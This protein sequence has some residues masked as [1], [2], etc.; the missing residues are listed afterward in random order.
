MEIRL[1]K[2]F[3]KLV[4]GNIKIVQNAIKGLKK[5]WHLFRQ[6]G[7]FTIMKE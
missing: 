3:E 4:K 2:R 7:D 6:L 5:Q 1:K